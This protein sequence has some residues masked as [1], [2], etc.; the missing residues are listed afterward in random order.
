[1]IICSAEEAVSKI[2]SGNRVFIHSV[3]A[4]PQLLIKA[5]VAR[6]NE[7]KNVNI[8]HLHT[9]GEAPYTAP[10]MEEH[11]KLDA[12]FIGANVRKAINEKR[13]DF[14]PVFLSEVPLLFK[15]NI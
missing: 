2:L 14:I 15:Q 3:A 9:E 7:L 11:F 6:K 13:A 1:M 5:M 12:F 8:V 10:G 4:A